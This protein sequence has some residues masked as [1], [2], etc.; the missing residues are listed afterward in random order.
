M[1]NLKRFLLCFLSCMILLS[2]CQLIKKPE[3]STTETSKEAKKIKKPNTKKDKAKVDKVEEE[4]ELIFA[5]EEVEEKNVYEVGYKSITGYFRKLK[6]DSTKYSALQKNIDTLHDE[7]KSQNIKYLEEKKLEM[8]ALPENEETFAV[9]SLYLGY[10]NMRSDSVLV[11]YI[12]LE[13]VYEDITES[14]EEVK[15]HY[16]NIDTQ[17]GDGLEFSDIVMDTEKIKEIVLAE[18]KE[19]VPE[20]KLEGESLES[21]IQAALDGEK[22]IMG[23]EGMYLYLTEKDPIYESMVIQIPYKKYPDIFSSNYIRT[24]KEYTYLSSQN[25]LTYINIGEGVETLRLSKYGVEEDEEGYSTC[26]GYQIEYKGEN[27]PFEKSEEPDFYEIGSASVVHMGDGNTYLY[28]VYSI[29]G[30]GKLDIIKITQ[31]GLEWVA[32]QEFLLREEHFN[33]QNFVMWNIIH[34]L[35]SQWV[36]AEFKVGEDGVPVRISELY[37]IDS[38]ISS[39]GNGERLTFTVLQ[40][41]TVY[42]LDQDNKEIE[43]LR[44]NAGDTLIPLETDIDSYVNVEL[45]DGRK[46]RLKYTMETVTEEYEGE[47][48]EYE[49]LKIEGMPVVEVLDGLIFAD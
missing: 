5:Q 24:S 8:E 18:G 17:T 23:Y 12:E 46:A 28:V 37:R 47:T 16:R 31:D 42:I 34:T 22:F 40:P 39:A 11:S 41:F 6:F 7:L 43:E 14:K 9:T 36:E 44:L 13:S 27:Y 48:Y 15:Y 25:T 4:V 38:D 45:A 26:R 30:Y 35:G 20:E 32:D 33:P 49:E 1:R 19:Q 3:E 29:Y 2:A 21:R 10:Q